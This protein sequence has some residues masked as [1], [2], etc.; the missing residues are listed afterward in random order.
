MDDLAVPYTDKVIDRS[1]PLRL[2]LGKEFG[3]TSMPAVFVGGKFIGGM[4][5]GSPGLRN[6]DVKDLPK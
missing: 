5:D 6:L 1:D 3:R 4:N 2:E